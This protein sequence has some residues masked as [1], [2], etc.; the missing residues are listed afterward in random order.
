MNESFINVFI[1]CVVLILYIQI[2]H[3]S[4]VSDDLEVFE[5]TDKIE[6]KEKLD[7]VLDYLQPTLFRMEFMPILSL[8]SYSAFD[9]RIRN[10]S[11]VQPF[12]LPFCLK[13]ANQL[14]DTDSSQNYFSEHNFEFLQETGLVKQYEHL[15]EILKPSS[16]CYHYYDI[17]MGSVNVATPLRYHVS[18]RHFFCLLEGSVTI[19]ICPPKNSKYLNPI[20]DYEN[21]E[22]RSDQNAWKDDPLQKV[23]FM[24]VVIDKPGDFLSIPPYWWYTIKFNTKNTRIASFMYRT[25]MNNAYILPHYIMYL[26]QNHNIKN[27]VYTAKK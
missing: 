24:N 10:T 4:K 13:D 11:D 26:L 8:D 5:L 25:C 18:Y 12:Y 1:F 14:F 2:Y 23:K 15:E 6:T 7:E 19:K 22:F 9:L 21:F 27:I 20:H 16:C 3:H 17:L